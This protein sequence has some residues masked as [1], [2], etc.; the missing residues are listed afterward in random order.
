[1]SWWL[2]TLVLAGCGRTS[3][4]PALQVDEFS[5]DRAR[6]HVETLVA[7]GPRPSGSPELAHA[8]AYLKEQL[9]AAGLTVEEQTFHAGTPRGPVQFRNVIGHTRPTDRGRLIVLGSHYD[10][11]WFP[12]FRFVGANDGGSSTGVLLELARVA[13]GTRDLCFV[14]FDGEEAV[15]EYG[16]QDGLW[17]SQYFVEDLKSRGRTGAIEALILLDMV[18]DRDLRITIPANSTGWLAQQAFAAARTLGYRDQFGYSQ[19]RIVDDH[20][21]FLA[22]GIPAVNLID[23]EFGSAPGRHDYWHTA[24]DTIDKVSASSLA[25]AGRVTLQMVQQLRR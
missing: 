6:A 20:V 23:F 2:L 21:P 22:A 25:V 13:A 9:H 5:G 19:Q 4:P 14:F 24:A 15:H 8:A 16:P 1:M 18:G 12:Q 3:P 10:T 7:L 11:K 17:G